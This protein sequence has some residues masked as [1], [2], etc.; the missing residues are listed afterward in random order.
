MIRYLEPRLKKDL[1]KKMV[2]LLGARQV[3]K[4]TLARN[5]ALQAGGQYLS[6]DNL[7][8]R[9]VI[10]AR[11]WNKRAPLLALDEIHKM[12]DWKQWL[13]GVYDGKPTGQQILVTGS[14]RIDTFR[15]SGESL[16]GR[17]FPLRMHP[18]SVHELCTL[19]GTE[20]SPD[21]AYAQ[22]LARGGFPEPCLNS[23]AVDAAR[24]RK[25]YYEGMVR[26]DILEFSRLHEVAAMRLFVEL[27]RTRVGALLSMASIARDLNISPVTVKRYL[28]ILE[29]LYIVFTIKPW[30]KNIARATQHMPKVYF[31][32]SGLV[33]G[34]TGVVFENIV[35]N[36][37][38]KY[39]EW[40]QDAY[41]Q[42]CELHYL[43]T[44]DGAEIDFALRTDDN[45]THL[46][47][48]KVSDIKPHRA[49]M[50]FATEAPQVQAVQLVQDAK[51]EMTVGNIKVCPAPQWL[52]E[53]GV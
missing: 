50:R 9:T 13:K 22:L 11:A 35:A 42:D 2:F 46:I 51:H 6:W 18:L 3:G 17:Y 12:P 8:D 23:D 40:Q 15:L 39:A 38:L 28:N 14:A 45:L 24:W 16:A 25:Q 53:L 19:L 10:E 48:C 52:F 36:H 26:D 32:D 20:P 21:A 5:L 31:F 44:K 37:L 33:K 4:T 29:A 1:N 43:R 7:E 30:H 49:L 47:E 41:G 34:D 27:L